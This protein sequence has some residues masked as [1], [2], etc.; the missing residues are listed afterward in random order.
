MIEVMDIPIEDELIDICEEIIEQNKSEQQW[1][2]IESGDMFQSAMF[3]GGF[4][5][6]ENKFCFSYFSS[7]GSEYWFQF[8]LSI[9]KRIASRSSVTISGEHAK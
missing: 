5:A 8:G 1:A 6:D 3:C 4:D 7:T 2:E 9:A